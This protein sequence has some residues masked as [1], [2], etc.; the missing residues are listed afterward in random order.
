MFVITIIFLSL[1]D[2]EKYITWL[3]NFLSVLSETKRGSKNVREELKWLSKVNYIQRKP[4]TPDG[5]ISYSSS[6]TNNLACLNNGRCS[7]RK[8]RYS[9]IFQVNNI[10]FCNLIFNCGRDKTLLQ[11]LVN[12]NKWI[13]R[14]DE[15][16][17]FLRRK[18]AS[19]LRTFKNSLICYIIKI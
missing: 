2:C 10:P 13:K 15:E 9:M 19:K 16:N 14:S 17:K 11:S 5:I 8:C 3:Q 6:C 18:Q 1:E 7:D 4:T 12:E